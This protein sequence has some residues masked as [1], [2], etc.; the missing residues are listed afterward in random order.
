MPVT[1]Y[2]RKVLH[3]AAEEEMR[4]IKRDIENIVGDNAEAWNSYR[5][6]KP[7]QQ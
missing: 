2:Y 5:K 6:E 3:R 4:R 7:W 1:G